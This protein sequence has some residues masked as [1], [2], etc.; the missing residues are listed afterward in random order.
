MGQYAMGTRARAHTGSSGARAPPSGQWRTLGCALR[1]Q[2]E[3]SEVVAGAGPGQGSERTALLR[4]VN[5]HP[6]LY[7][8][9]L[10]PQPLFFLGFPFC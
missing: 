5:A 2:E 4:E 7:S 6:R 3:G 9:F 8:P 1:M 10:I